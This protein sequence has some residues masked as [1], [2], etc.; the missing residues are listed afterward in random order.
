MRIVLVAQS[1]RWITR[2]RAP[3]PVVADVWN[4]RRN[5]IGT[6]RL[7]FALVVVV[8]HGW[9]LALGRPDP[10]TAASRGQT[11]VGAMAVAGFFV[12]SGLLV[13]RSAQRV[14]PG[15][16]AWHRALRILPGYW[17]CMLAMVLVLGPALW[18]VRE[19]TLAGYTAA[20]PGPREFLTGNWFTAMRHWGIG[21]LLTTTPYGH[22]K[23]A[24]VLN[25]SLWTLRYEMFCYLAVGVLAVAGVVGV[26]RRRPAVLVGLAGVL[27]GMV[28]LDWLVND[29][30]ATGPSL[31][32][33]LRGLP[34]LGDLGGSSLFGFALVF[35][36]GAVAAVRPD[37][38]P[39]STRLAVVA[40][41]VVAGSLRFG[42]WDVAGSPAFAYLTL[43]A[44]MRA[45]AAVGALAPRADLSYGVYI[46]AFPIQQVL[47]LLHVQRHGLLPYLVT[48]IA[49]ALAAGWVSWHVVERPALRLKD[50]A[51]PWATAPVGARHAVRTPG[52]LLA[53][54]PVRVALG[55]RAPGGGRLGDQSQAAAAAVPLPPAPRR[56]AADRYGQVVAPHAGDGLVAHADAVRLAVPLAPPAQPHAGLLHHAA[57]GQVPG[58]GLG[59]D[60]RYADVVEQVPQQRA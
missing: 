4:P 15:R 19:D 35:A 46:Y 40:A 52:R 7:A 49:G 2:V 50:V 21:D 36:I 37:R 31:L 57:A 24:S 56:P 60:A 23:G 5:A 59:L 32:P 41:V 16:F 9:P 27:Y 11:D 58:G 45:P 33:D 51:A 14:S 30:F 55:D 29:R 43:W 34:L 39:V 18:W 6:L 1:D 22:E 38:F 17:A 53:L 3:L 13:T 48:S 8:S 42:G 47:A 25:G 44:A 28:G 54:T 10:L 26:A 20:T 12:L